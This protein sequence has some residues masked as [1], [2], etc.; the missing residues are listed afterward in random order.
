MEIKP[1]IARQRAFFRSGGTRMP[2]FRRLM[3]RRLADVV[4]GHEAEL[5]EAL[6]ADLRK[7]PQEAYASEVGFAISE[8]R[9]AL[10][11]LDA[12]MKPERRRSPL[13]AW[14]AKAA[15][16]A[17]PLGVVLIIGPWNYPL[18]LLISPLVGAI[19]AGN[20]AIFKPSELAPR[21]S[22]VVARMIAS[23]FPED[24]IA[25][26]EG[27]ADTAEAL[28]AEKFDSIFFTGSTR[29][30]RKVMAAAAENLTPVTLELGGKSPCI[31]CA[32]APLET[33]AR[34]IAWGKFMNAGQTCVAP[35]HVWVDRRVAADF[36]GAMA[37]VLR[38]FHGEDARLSADYGRIINGAHFERVCGYL[39]SGKVA[40]GGAHDAADLYIEP[41]L[42]TGVPLD[43]PAMSEEIFGPV[44]PVIE[45]GD[46]G[47]VLDHL[48]DQPAP[49]ALYLFTNDRAVRERVLANTR[50]GGVC[51]NDTVTHLLAKDLP[52][53]GVGESGMGSSH[54]KAGFDAFSHRRSVM[55]RST[56][57]DPKFRYP[58]A[59]L[60]LPA[61]KRMLRIFGAG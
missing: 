48:R 21:T 45:F 7:S 31:V 54:G 33:A 56:A 28:L 35:D 58:P 10:A 40:I 25:V 55:T 20:C 44:L 9:H 6:R 41:T 29:I 52:F 11:H 51:I 19:A 39:D 30:G 38:E 49:L 57:M 61:L 17:E 46:I 18:Q 8:I 53:G 2:E 37:K 12:W 5:L 23:V 47:G 22:A 50:S 43:S 59:P 34:R 16:R 15:V 13:I 27:G 42:L 24:F 3:L 14:P 60:G 26:V 36:L 4:A 32:D 1:L